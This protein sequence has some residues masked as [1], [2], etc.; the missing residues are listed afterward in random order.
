MISAI[1][2]TS[3]SGHTA[4]YA[5]LLGQA[6][7][8][9]VNDLRQ[10][11]NPQPEQEVIYLGWLMAG[12]VMGLQKAMKMFKVRAIC[13]VGMSPADEAAHDAWK[14]KLGRADIAVFSLQGGFDRKKLHGPYRWIM[15][16]MCRRIRKMLEE[17]G[18]LTPEQQL[19]YDMVTKGASNVSREN[20]QGVIDWYQQN[21]QGG[22]S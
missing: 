13:R 19:T 3:H 10:M 5:E 1:V 4:Q 16:P 15:G 7:G 17:K 12:Q 11:R 6:T 8:L 18:E 20:L 14:E 9:P 22:R 21:K 2:Y